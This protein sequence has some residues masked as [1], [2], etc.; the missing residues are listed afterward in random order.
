MSFARKVQRTKYQS[1]GTTQPGIKVT[2]HRQDWYIRTR[3]WSQ[4][5]GGILHVRQHR[6]FYVT[7]Y[8]E[9]AD[10]NKEFVACIKCNSPLSDTELYELQRK[11][12]RH[13]E[14]LKSRIVDIEEAN[15]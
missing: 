14:K 9:D 11:Y 8:I 15:L 2:N 10:R 4:P 12:F 1:A 7:M 5:K 3:S 6:N 13:P